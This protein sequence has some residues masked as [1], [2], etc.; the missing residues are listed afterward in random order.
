MQNLPP[1]FRTR[2]IKIV[3][4]S[5]LALST[6]VATA[7]AETKPVTDTTRMYRYTD[8]NG[9]LVTSSSISP[10]YSKRG[11]QIVTITGVVV[12]TVPPEPTPE[13][14]EKLAEAEKAKLTA[15]QQAVQDKELLLR[16]N[17]VNDIQYARERR[18]SEIN[19]QIILL[20]SNVG[21]LKSQLDTEHQRAAIFERNGQPVPAVQ[22]TK[23]SDLQQAI[24][25]T[26]DQVTQRQQELASETARFDYETERLKV[27]T[28]NR[29]KK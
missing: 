1:Q 12:A 28:Q 15:A 3:T 11:Y 21:T 20:N 29:P 10:E 14:R 13:E 17:T 5:F 7:Y 26:E 25:V 4:A 9:A 18:L 22:L 27:L 23:I 19:N 6:I 2:R 8:K 16:Y 24:K